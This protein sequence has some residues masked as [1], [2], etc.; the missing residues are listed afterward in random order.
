MGTL[1]KNIYSSQ[2][3]DLFSIAMGQ[4]VTSFNKTS[5]LTAVHGSDWSELEL[6]QRMHRISTV[7]KDYFSPDYLESVE[8]I[9]RLVLI[10]KGQHYV[11]GGLAFMFLPDFIEKYGINSFDVSIK[12]FEK[13]TSF[14]SCEFAV[15]P[16]IIKYKADMINRM[17]EWADNEDEHIRRLASEGCRPKLPWAMALPALIENP[18]A[19]L[20][21]LEKLKTDPSEYVRRSVAN[22]L[23]D[24]SKNHPN[25]IIDLSKLWLG[26]SPEVDAVVKHACRTLLKAGDQTVMPIFGL[27][28]SDYIDVVDFNLVSKNVKIGTE[29]KFQFKLHNRSSRNEKLRLEY[30]I[31]F[32]KKNK[33]LSRKVFK[34]SEKVYAAKSISTINK[35]QSFRIIS[36]R[37]Y[38]V[39]I[40]FV[41]VIVNGVE[42]GKK[43]FELLHE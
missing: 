20:P 13:I 37:K 7:L 28:A 42:Q 31:Y 17:I 43:S 19:I 5:F 26:E 8:Q 25:L 12:A 4:V 33:S 1:L 40:H 10:I 23:N 24:I 11:S 18:T 41:S 34:I 21:I 22:N 38:Y 39:G 3:F 36:T 2:F 9:H 29:L 27:S 15:R 30:G 35:R 14:T 16:F 6:K 32:L